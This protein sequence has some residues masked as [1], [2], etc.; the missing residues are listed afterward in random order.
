MRSLS[1]DKMVASVEFSS[2]LQLACVRSGEVRAWNYADLCKLARC[3][4][5]LRQDAVGADLIM[6]QSNS[7]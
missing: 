6:I 5:D 7:E 4:G 2:E 3:L 1:D